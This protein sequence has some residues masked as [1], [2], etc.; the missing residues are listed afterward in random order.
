MNLTINLIEESDNG[1]YKELMHRFDNIKSVNMELTRDTNSVCKIGLLFHIGK[2]FIKKNLYLKNID[3]DTASKLLPNLKKALFTNT[4]TLAEREYSIVENY[5]TI[6]DTN[7][8][9]SITSK[10]DI[11]ITDNGDT[12]NYEHVLVDINIE[13]IDYDKAIDNIIDNWV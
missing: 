13:K 11:K 2:K 12:F 5:L 1:E 7:D 4:V 9:I 6:R 10:C 3:K 8:F